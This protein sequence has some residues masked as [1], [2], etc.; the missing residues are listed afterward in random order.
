MSL[1][2]QS[3]IRN[4]C[5]VAHIDHGKSTLADRILE[6][7]HA[8]GERQMREQV[9]D[10]M[11]LERERGITIKASAIRSTYRARDGQ[12]YLLN[13]IDTPGHV[14]F[15]YEVS[16]SL[17][18]AEGALLVVDAAQ[19][20]EAQTVAN[21]H[22]ALDQGLQ[23][24]PVINKIDLPNASPER[25]LMELEEIIGLDPSEALLVSAKLGTGVEEVLEAVVQRVP[26]PSGDSAAPLQALIFDSH[27]DPHRGIVAYV[28]VR[29]GRL[30]A[31]MPILM[32]STGHRFEVQEV[33]AFRLRLERVNELR[34]G[35]VGYV[36]AAMKEIGQA[37][38]GETITD[39]GHP[40]A[41]PLPG[42][43]RAKPMV[44]CGIYPSENP[45]YPYL[46]SALE[47]LSLNDAALSYEPE[48]S[49]ALGFGFRCGF[50][51][52]LHMD[53]VQERLEREYA[54]DLVATAPSVVYRVHTTDG[55]VRDIDSPAKLPPPERIARIEEPYVR[56][57]IMTPSAYV[58][59]CLELCQDRRGE[60][61]KMEQSH[62][63][64]V[65]ITYLL[66]LSEILLDFFDQLKSRSRGYASLDYEF[67]GYREEQLAKLDILI[68]GAPVDALSVITHRSRAQHRGRVLVERLRKVLP[69]QLFEIRIQAA[70]ASR[71]I[72]SER[73]A[74][75]RKNVLA[76]CYGGDVT[77]K[78]KLLERQ[79]AGKKRMRQIGKI[80]VPQ[81]AFLT[82]LK[83]AD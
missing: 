9:L 63:D 10:Q 7:T 42:Y 43:R 17:A 32:M 45:D 15:S 61:E 76:K 30:A 70:L 22:L 59:P 69:R 54:L 78:R 47:K 24:I 52:L 56:A 38:V 65:V 36:I 41:T 4:F 18:A 74:P 20:V 79:K 83:I 13:L 27:F 62:T 34:A 46:R 26:P 57:T 73:V 14:D 6:L 50:L 51:G 80:D 37:P 40:A 19:G 72:A 8:L 31:G 23:I 82:V 1:P 11:E 55:E 25:A 28:R 71:I 49:A 66:P 58:G 2:E 35:E 5:I 48:T 12:D 44:F 75:L 67:A 53:I 81:E 68:N 29:N 39:A 16:R 60:Y 64:R 21:V 33:G 77:R 3:R